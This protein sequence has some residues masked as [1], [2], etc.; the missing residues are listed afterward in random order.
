[1]VIE[2]EVNMTLGYFAS[3]AIRDSFMTPSYAYYTSNLL[4]VIPPGRLNTSLEKL[5]RPFQFAVWTFFILTLGA[6]L[7]FASVIQRCSKKLQD[8]F[9]GVGNTSPCLNIINLMFG[10]SLYKLPSRNIARIL[11]AFFMIYCFI[12]QNSYK[13]GLFQFMQMT[14]REAEVKSTDEMISKNFNFYML[15]SSSA[16]MTGMPK[17]LE[18]TIFVTPTNFSLLM[19]EVVAPEFKG[20]LLSSEDHLAYR[21]IHAS[22]HQFFRHAPETI[23]TYNIVIYMHKQSCLASEMNQKIMYLVNGGL[24][25]TWAAQFT[26]KKFLKHA[27][28]SKAVGI[29]IVQLWGAFQLLYTGLLMGTITFVLELLVIRF[30]KVK[31]KR[32][33]FVS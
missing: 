23:L 17:V 11:L 14:L 4:W 27:A 15:K 9:F 1:M 2:K 3:T 22:P 28:T 30:S 33:E 10:G 29:N 25:Q 31:E 13:G 20:A 24:V 12:I 18:R 16:F 21:N 32:F 19:S 6:S 5:L 8:F 7:T 26:D